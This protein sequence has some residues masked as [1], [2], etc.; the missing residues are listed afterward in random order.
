MKEPA[1][2]HNRGLFLRSDPFDY[3]LNLTKFIMNIPFLV[4]F[5]RQSRHII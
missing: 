1:A 2:D 4:S 3:K 5:F